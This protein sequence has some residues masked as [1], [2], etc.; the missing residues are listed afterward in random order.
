MTV[1]IMDVNMT[2]SF[3]PLAARAGRRLTAR[4]S[5][6]AASVAGSYRRKLTSSCPCA[7]FASEQMSV[8]GKN[9]FSKNGDTTK[10]SIRSPLGQKSSHSLEGI[11]L[12]DLLKTAVFPRSTHLM[13]WRV[14]L[15]Q[16]TSVSPAEP[17]PHHHT[18]SSMLHS[19]GTHADTIC[20]FLDPTTSN[21]DSSDQSRG[22][23]WSDV[24][25]LSFLSSLVVSL[26]QV[27]HERLIQCVCWCRRVSAVRP[28]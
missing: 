7:S 4:G 14:M 13:G 24:D 27:D 2:L 19:G 20:S 17:H 12:I 22:F 6:R 23:H 25:S 21:L 28:L 5:A 15:V 10:S 8:R 18:S 26:Q 11:W 3:M 16:C 9:G 1:N